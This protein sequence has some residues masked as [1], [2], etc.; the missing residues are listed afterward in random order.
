M[1]RWKEAVAVS[2]VNNDLPN[3]QIYYICTKVK[4]AK[5]KQSD[6]EKKMNPI[7]ICIR[8]FLWFLKTQH[9]FFGMTPIWSF[10]SVFFFSSDL[11]TCFCI[12]FGFSCIQLYSY[13]ICFL[14][15]GELSQS[16][17]SIRKEIVIRTMHKMCK[18]DCCCCSRYTF[19]GNW[20]LRQTC[21]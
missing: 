8:L 3:T 9:K 10:C 20:L 21:S 2:S 4:A 14:L 19:S 11:H 5:D 7:L 15:L 16:R 17:W 13:S 18:R 6:L 12:L 1:S